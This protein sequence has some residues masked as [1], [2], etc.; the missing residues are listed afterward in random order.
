MDPMSPYKLDGH[1]FKNS[2]NE[3]LI[4]YYESPTPITDEKRC[5]S[6][7]KM[8]FHYFGEDEVIYDRMPVA[9]NRSVNWTFMNCCIEGEEDFIPSLGYYRIRH[10]NNLTYAYISA[11]PIDQVGLPVSIETVE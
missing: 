2:F 8:N 6:Y 11:I 5:L 9:Y 3:N 10:I 4:F 1:E 7:A